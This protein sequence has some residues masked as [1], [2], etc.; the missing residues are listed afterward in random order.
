MEFNLRHISRWIK[1]MERYFKVQHLMIRFW[2]HWKHVLSTNGATC[3]FTLPIS[4]LP[5]VCGHKDPRH[6]LECHWPLIFRFSHTSGIKLLLSRADKYFRKTMSVPCMM[7]SSNGNIS[8]LLALCAGNS[9]VTGEFPAQRAVTR[10]FDVF[11]A[12]ING[13]VN[14]RKAGD[15]RH[16]RAHCDVT[17]MH[18]ED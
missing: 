17:V 16:H 12:W 13:W 18:A 10:S 15:L 14:N 1:K 11:C 9:V 3:K 6:S 2:Q 8:A 5:M 7:T 4:C